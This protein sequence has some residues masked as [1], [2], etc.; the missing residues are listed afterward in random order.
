MFQARS[1]RTVI[2]RCLTAAERRGVSPKDAR[3]ER[4]LEAVGAVPVRAAVGHRAR[5]LLGRWRLLDLLPARSRPQPRLSLGRRRPA[6]LLRPRVPALPSRSRSGTASDPILK[7][8]LFGL[9]GPEGN[10]G[11][12]VKECYYYLDA[13]PT[14][15]YIKA[16]YKY[17]QARF[18]VRGAGRRRTGG[19]ASSDPEFEL[20]DTG[21]FD[22]DRYFDVTVEYAKARRTTC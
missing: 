17:P 21:V 15:S 22:E 16:L 19:A 2:A 1:R 8:R 9:T 13:T 7:E 10:H 11:E 4:K 18:P 6:R 3:R 14:H 20:V 5:G 12:D